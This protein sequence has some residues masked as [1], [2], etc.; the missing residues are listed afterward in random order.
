MP[1][2]IML[3]LVLATLAALSAGSGTLALLLLGAAV[4][5]GCWCGLVAVGLIMDA[6]TGCLPRGPRR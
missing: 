4:L 1:T 3:A 6:L 2:L 5:W